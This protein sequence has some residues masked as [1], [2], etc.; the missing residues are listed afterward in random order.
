MQR[1]QVRRTDEGVVHVTLDQPKRKNAIDAVMWDELGE[2]FREVAESDSDRVLVLT[3]AGDD[4]CAGAD[5][6]P[7]PASRD[8]HQLDKMHH[9]GW[10]G[11]AL[12][13]IPKPT[14]AKVNGIAVGAGLNLALGC[15]LIVAGQSARFSEIFAKR[16]L[17][18]DLGGSWL[19][20]R[21]VGMHKAKELA[22][23]ADIVSAEEAER[24]GIVNRVVPDAELDAFVDDWALRL[25]TGPPLALQ[26]T[27]RMITSAFSSSF[28]EALHWEAM[29]QS[30]TGTS[31]DTQEAMEAFFAK[32]APVFKGR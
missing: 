13:E 18:V 23:L 5:L 4:F 10:V 32:R 20:P 27:K 11:L 8:K 14:I 2:T 22:L 25:A 15:D 21:L 6:T 26:M 9:Y 30:V 7:D 16:G 17:A 24:I 1:L 19:L 29:A 12:H 28:S 3:G 31:K